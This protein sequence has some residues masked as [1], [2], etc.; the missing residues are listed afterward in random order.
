[1][2]DSRDTHPVGWIA[3]EKGLRRTDY[4]GNSPV[5]RHGQVAA[6]VG[7]GVE[8]TA[9]PGAAIQADDVVP[10]GS[11]LLDRHHAGETSA[12]DCDA[13]AAAQ[14]GL[15]GVGWRPAAAQR[16]EEVEGADVEEREERRGEDHG[17]EGVGGGCDGDEGGEP[18][19]WVAD[20]GGE[21]EGRRAGG[22]CC[23]VM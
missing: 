14:L 8:G 15:R 7:V 21:A 2:W 20:R 22:K 1:M 12:D 6:V 17:V 10:L 3:N 11:Q 23:G 18:A 13:E 5:V 16:D 9:Q 4:Y 19:E